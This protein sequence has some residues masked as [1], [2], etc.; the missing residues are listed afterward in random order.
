MHLIRLFFSVFLPFMRAHVPSSNKMALLIDN[1]AVHNKDVLAND[2]VGNIACP[3][4]AQL[5]ISQWI[6][7]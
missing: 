1:F 2:R 6:G 4:I 7:D 5:S 3:Q